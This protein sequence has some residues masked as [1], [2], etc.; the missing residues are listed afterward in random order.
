MPGRAH[1]SKMQINQ[2]VYL[3]SQCCCSYGAVFFSRDFRRGNF[4]PLRFKKAFY[5]CIIMQKVNTSVPKKTNI[6]SQFKNPRIN[7]AT[8]SAFLSGST[9]SR[10]AKVTGSKVNRGGGYGLKIPCKY[11]FHGPKNYIDKLKAIC[12]EIISDS[13]L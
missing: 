8:V 10:V 6:P 1:V 2:Q 13:L 3:C 5:L 11:T 4:P 12:S 7:S 9:N